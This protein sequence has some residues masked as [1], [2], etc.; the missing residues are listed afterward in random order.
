MRRSASEIVRNLEM[1]IA[2]LEK[3]SKK[4]PPKAVDLNKLPDTEGFW[5]MSLSDL[6]AIAPVLRSNH[7]GNPDTE[8]ADIIMFLNMASSAWVRSNKGRKASSRTASLHQ[9]TGLEMVSMIEDQYNES[10]LDED[11]IEVEAEGVSRATGDT[12]LLVSLEGYYGIV[13][14]DGRREDV[15]VVSDD[16]RKIKKMYDNNLG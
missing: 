2:Q 16:Y 14:V 6:K 5:N 4:F 11:Y 9:S 8:I 3:Q 12:L 15:E 10:G 13:R 1:R 7:L